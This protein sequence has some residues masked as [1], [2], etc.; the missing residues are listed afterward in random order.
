[1]KR[2]AKKDVIMCIIAIIIGIIAIYLGNQSEKLAGVIMIIL[3]A[4]KL[5]ERYRC[6]VENADNNCNHF[7]KKEG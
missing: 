6:D 4:I 7:E 5:E 2:N 1:M 3:G